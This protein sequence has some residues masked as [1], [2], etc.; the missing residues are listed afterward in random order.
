MNFVLPDCTNNVGCP[1]G[2]SEP[3]SAPVPATV[4]EPPENPEFGSVTVVDGIAQYSCDE[5]RVLVGD[6]TRTCSGDSTWSG[7]EPTCVQAC[8][9]KLQQ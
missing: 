3:T 8:K 6:A 2:G 4:C 7:T 5:G 9:C 1:I